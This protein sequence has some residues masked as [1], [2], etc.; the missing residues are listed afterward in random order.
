MNIELYTESLARILEET[1][2]QPRLRRDRIRALFNEAALLPLDAGRAA[3][4]LTIAT[5]TLPHEPLFVWIDPRVIVPEHRRDSKHSRLVLTLIKNRPT[6]TKPVP[7]PKMPY[8]ILTNVMAITPPPNLALSH[9]TNC[10]QQIFDAQ[11]EPSSTVFDLAFME[12]SL[13][14]IADDEAHALLSGLD[15][16]PGPLRFLDPGPYFDTDPFDH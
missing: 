5:L 14:L 4:L 13:D 10:P 12:R 6:L 16:D 15:R 8:L 11:L 7:D 9:I 2:S 1:K 3:N